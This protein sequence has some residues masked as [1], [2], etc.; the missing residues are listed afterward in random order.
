MGL[1]CK[2][3]MGEE[4]YDTK[5]IWLRVVSLSY[6]SRV[7]ALVQEYC[8]FCCGGAWGKVVASAYFSSFLCT[9]FEPVS[10]NTAAECQLEMCSV[11]FVI[12]RCD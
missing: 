5:V 7:K 11:P 10:T 2:I 1:I 9:S 12:C 3:A 6:V 8:A 4:E